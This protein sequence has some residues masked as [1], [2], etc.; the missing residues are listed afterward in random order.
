[1]GDREETTRIKKQLDEYEEEWVK[2]QN[3]EKDYQAEADE[4]TRNLETTRGQYGPAAKYA[5]PPLSPPVFSFLWDLKSTYLYLP[6]CSPDHGFAFQIRY[7]VSQICAELLGLS[8]DPL[9]TL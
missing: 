4:A 2:M 1:M 3:M 8:T 9:H 5:S 6:A 7:L